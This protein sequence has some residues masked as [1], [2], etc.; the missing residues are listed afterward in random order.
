MWFLEVK[1]LNRELNVI[2][3]IT[4][5]LPRLFLQGKDA[6]L[7]PMILSIKLLDRTFVRSL[8]SRIWLCFPPR[9]IT[10]M[11]L[12]K[13]CSFALWCRPF[14]S[15][16]SHRITWKGSDSYLQEPKKIILSLLLK[17]NILKATELNSRQFLDEKEEQ[18]GA[19]LCH[20]NK[21]DLTF[22]MIVL[23]WCDCI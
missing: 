12:T 21:K 9:T 15:V 16:F 13:K 22:L 20:L 4:F 18:A 17:D 23:L 10:T 5:Y 14:L 11:N 8:R 3:K 1:V 7:E 6:T 19:E 2:I